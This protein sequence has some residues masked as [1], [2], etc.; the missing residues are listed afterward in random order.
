MH[1]KANSFIQKW[2]GLPRCLSETGLFGKSILQL[3]LQSISMDC[4]QEKTKLVLELRES[5]DQAVWGKNVQVHTGHKW[6]AH[7]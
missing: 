7:A 6:N 2:L 4:K 3:L 5:N 1:G